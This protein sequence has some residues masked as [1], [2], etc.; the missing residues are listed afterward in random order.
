[1][2]KIKIVI[3]N[4]TINEMLYPLLF[5]IITTLIIIII[6]ILL[7]NKSLKRSDKK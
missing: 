1:M 4:I 7:V 6:T 2:D 5:T 3:N